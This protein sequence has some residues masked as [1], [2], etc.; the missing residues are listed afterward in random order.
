[1]RILYGVN[2]Y[3]RG[4]A[5]R[6]LAVLPELAK[7]HQLLVLA[8]GDAYPAF[9]AEYQVVRIPTLGFAY[10]AT[11]NGQ[12]KRSNFATIRRNFPAAVDLFCNGPTFTMVREIVEEFAPDIVISDAET[13]THHVAAS[14]KIPRIGFDHIGIMAYCI[15]E[16]DLLDRIKACLDTTC[17][18]TLMGQ[19]DRILI[20]SFYDAPPS[21]PGVRVIGT[22]PRQTVREVVPT[23]GSHLLVYLNRGQDQLHH[24]LINTLDA[25]G[26]PVHIYGTEKRGWQGRLS[27]MPPSN[28]PFLEDLA[29]CRA[30]ISTAGNQLIGESIFLGKP[31]L[32]LPESC[33]EQ[34]MNALAVERLGIGIRVDPRSFSITHLRNYVER[35]DELRNNL[36]PHVRDGLKE[37]L[38]VLDQFFHELVP[39]WSVQHQPALAPDEVPIPL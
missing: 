4:H 2:G 35:I 32:V 17:Y 27:F 30:V 33:V 31:V 8:G 11:S 25:I 6:T 19:P 1:M 10:R 13:W 28:L 23:I 37:A 21:R 7:Q 29:S 15:P 5:T 20:S 3:G 24:E 16:L 36:K 39:S 9:T 14:L 18:R 12:R 34:R 22:L 26:L 38:T